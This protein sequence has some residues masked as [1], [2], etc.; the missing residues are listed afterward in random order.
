MKETS[1]LEQLK[2]IPYGTLLKIMWLDA[3]TVKGAKIDKLP[4]PNYY[5]ETR[6]IVIGEYVTLQQGQAQKAY[7]LVLRMDDTEGSGSMIR[8]ILVCLIYKIIMSST[9][10]VVE[11]VERYKVDKK[12][13]LA[14]RER[15]SIKLKD[16]S[17]K[18]LD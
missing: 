8:S 7:H 3:S 1:I 16:G 10:K 15:A 13:L 9:S 18:L 11:S 12:R 2:K 4:L 5:V 6:R 17:V 14:N